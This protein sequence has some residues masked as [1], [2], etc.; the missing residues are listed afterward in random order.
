M[1]SRFFVTL[2]IAVSVLL[3]FSCDKMEPEEYNGPIISEITPTE[4]YVND[5]VRSEER[6]VGEQC[7]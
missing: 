6:R 1:K 4:G 2:L 7:I 5:V 3:Y